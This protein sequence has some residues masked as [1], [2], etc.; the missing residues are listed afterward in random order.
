M[1]TI[2]S[3]FCEDFDGRVRPLLEP[4]DGFA[5][6]IGRLPADSPLKQLLPEV[7]DVRHQLRTLV[8]KV[9]EQ[10]AYVI[11]FGPLKSGKSTLMNAL[12]AAYVSEVTTLPAYPC[13][14]YVAN[15]DDE[16]FTVTRYDG[17]VDKFGDLASMRSLMETAHGELAGSIREVEGHGE[18]FDPASHMPQALRRVDV[19]MPTEPLAE[20]GAVLVD[21][22]GLYSRM[23]F[24]YDLMTREFRDSAASA[25]F[26][27][28]T[29]SLF[30][31]QVFDEFSDLLRL[32][33]RI[34]LIVNLDGT[35]QD[36][37]PDG[38]LGPSLE[39]RDPQRIIDAFESLSMNVEL[40]SAWEEGRLR[41]YPID[42]LQ[43]ASRRLRGDEPDEATEES[44][45]EEQAGNTLASFGG[46]TDDLTHYL[47]STEYMTAFLGDSLRQAEY[48]VHGLESV[49][50]SEPVHEL[51]EGLEKWDAERDCAQ[52]LLAA[53][54]RLQAF[55]WDETLARMREDVV[56]ITRERIGDLR[57]DTAEAAEGALARWYDGDAS[58]ASL[59]REDLEGVLATCRDAMVETASDV[60]A[61]V[62]S[63][64]VAGAM[65]RSETSDDLNLVGLSVAGIARELEGTVRSAAEDRQVT[66]EIPTRAIPVRRRLVDWLLLR[67]QASVRRSVFGPDDAPSR[68]IPRIVKQRRLGAGRVALGEAIRSRIDRLFAETLHRVGSEVYG[69]HV[70]AVC[71]QVEERLQTL[72]KENVARLATAEQHRQ[73]LAA[74]R[75]DVD[76][77][78]G[79]LGEA[80]QAI[81]SLAAAYGEPIPEREADPLELVEEVGVPEE[82]TPDLRAA[83]A[84]AGAGPSGDSNDS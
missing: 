40:K 75:S 74:L 28:K 6:Q 77:L 79:T 32:F 11:I 71:R 33:S 22:P 81:A 10:Q 5:A 78:A 82:A 9:A 58:Y 20:S 35:K 63:S 52:T 3:Q 45:A 7:I 42:L 23:K 25:I 61:T 17:S 49:C 39:R 60:S 41:I 26:V 37:Q 31:E 30:L 70:A 47:N 72:E 1:K 57:R 44:A 21:T 48:L 38:E 27:V 73:V 56:R 76:A 12:A 59:I 15:G 34:F 50:A 43:A 62:L 54:R 19:R 68:P 24:G 65:V 16:Q 2:L 51:S 83:A 14:V 69:A 67:S 64:D 46:F 84:A 29:D 13:M 18:D 55:P 8:E 36:L 80:S 53:V 66:P 4:L